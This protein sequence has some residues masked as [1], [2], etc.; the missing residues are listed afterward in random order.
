[1]SS[2]RRVGLAAVFHETNTFSPVATDRASF[3]HRWH[4]G[5]ELPAAAAGTSTV[6]GGF[7]DAAGDRDMAIVGLFGAFA[8]P[9]GLVTRDAWTAI[10]DALA[11]ALDSAPE[12]DGLL[13]ELHGAMAVDGIDDPEA[14][15]VRTV[16]DRLGPV[17]ISAVLDLHA[18]FATPRL[19]DVQ[20]LTGYRTNPHVDTYECGRRASQRL[21]DHLQ[22]PSR[23][24]RV[25]R[26]VPVVAAPIA[27]RTDAAPLHDILAL[28]ASEERAAGLLDVTVHAGYAY[29]DVPHLGMGVSVTAIADRRA[30]AD[31]AADAIAARAWET[32]EAFCH[33]LLAPAEA[34]DAAARRSADG[35][36]ALVDTGDNI[37]GGTPGDSTWLLAEALRRPGIAVAATICDPE[38]VAAAAAVG[39]RGRLD[40]PLGGGSHDSVGEPVSVHAEVVQVRDGS[41]RNTGPM[42]TG[43]AVSMGR[44]AVLRIGRIDVV[45]QER[46]LQPN[47]PELF[48]CMG[49][50]PADY[51][52]VILKG[53]A[54]VRAGWSDKV[55]GFV[56]AATP[57]ISD[58]RIDR[59][60]Y[61]HRPRPTWPFEAT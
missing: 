56:E 28:A 57:G 41:F 58:S 26:S 18:N 23:L 52:V 48:R 51:R 14:E 53:A 47:D 45:V 61:R 49:L 33:P 34:F 5:D 50:T 22:R 35:L 30:A 39:V 8:T 32:R 3:A 27:Q 10:T 29:A 55:V 11:Q 37:N 20:L 16:R 44:A 46:A 42:A 21:A 25:H 12:L 4:V 59:L 9:S 31:A 2:Q 7:L 36:V 40:L 43:A 6:I 19:G 13:L 17:P 38:A 1:M 24:V 15:I 54:A 60:S